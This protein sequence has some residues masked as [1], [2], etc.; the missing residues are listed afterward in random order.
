[1]RLEPCGALAVLL[2][3]AAC[4]G[5]GKKD[6]TGQKS[7]AS[8]PAASASA[9]TV[10]LNPGQWEFV[11]TASATPT[12]GMPAE[13]AKMMKSTKVST[14]QC[15]TPEEANRPTG[16]TFGGRMRGDCKQSE[17][18]LAAGKIHSVISCS[19]A[20]GRGGTTITSEGEYGG[21]AFD[22]RSRMSTDTGQGQMAM[23][24]HVAA[25][26]V[27]ECTGKEAG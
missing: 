8:A 21:D 11:V 23:E 3:L 1:M 7:G 19:G 24:S 16:H 14:L 20:N 2:A 25:R 13:V 4:G 9:G 27:G 17:L 12:P 22:V 10:K 5:S 18:N 26:R 6:E 15:I